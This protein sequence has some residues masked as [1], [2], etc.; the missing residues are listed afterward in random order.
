MARSE[1]TLGL[2]ARRS[3]VVKRKLAKLDKKQPLNR[4][5]KMSDVLEE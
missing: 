3:D 5:Q 2:G 4:G 1:A